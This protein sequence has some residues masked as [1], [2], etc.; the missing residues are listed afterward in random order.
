MDTEK[1]KL[2]VHNEFIKS[3]IIDTNVY[4]EF[5]YRCLNHNEGACYE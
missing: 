1:E 3:V 4:S 2:D 5:L